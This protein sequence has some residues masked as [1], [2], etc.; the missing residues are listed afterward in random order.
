MSEGGVSLATLLKVSRNGQSFLC[1]VYMYILKNV[2]G[3]DS[4]R[5][6]FGHCCCICWLLLLLLVLVLPL[7]QGAVGVSTICS[8]REPP[9]FGEA[10]GRG[11]TATA[12]QAVG[13]TTQS[14]KTRVCVCRAT[15]FFFFLCACFFGTNATPARCPCP[16]G[17]WWKGLGACIDGALRVARSYHIRGFARVLCVRWKP[18]Y[19]SSI[20][21]SC[22][23]HG[24]L[25]MC[26]S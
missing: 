12:P 23:T 6:S 22:C 24:G 2:S 4:E 19:Y 26:C 1:L 18:R 14:I 8:G 7:S 11:R 5:S 3:G 21:V 20:A 25:F 9:R 15:R 10:G 16:K 13:T 17:R